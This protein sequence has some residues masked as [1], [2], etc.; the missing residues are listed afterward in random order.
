MG[1]LKLEY[2]TEQM[3]FFLKVKRLDKQG[4]KKGVQGFL[5]VDPLASKYASISPYSA[6][7]NNPILFIDTDGR[8]FF[9]YIKVKN[10]ESGKTELKKVTF[11][12]VEASITDVKTGNTTAYSSGTSQFVDNMIT[13]YNYVVSN[14]A[15]VDNAM[16]TVAGSKDVQVEIVESKKG[17]S[18][19]KGKIEYDFNFGLKLYNGET[20]EYLGNQSSAIGF[21]SE[22]YHSYVDLI[23]QKAKSDLNG[24]I[25]KEEDYVHIS[26]EHKV[27]DKLKEKNPESK[28]TKRT[29]YQA[30]DAWPVKTEGA[31]STDEKK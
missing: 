16:Q 12:G 18:Y 24:D 11:N 19:F 1:C 22:V 26:K 2:H 8:E 13:S 6:F 15:D 27:I 23:D 28:E 29:Q 5:S 21:W 31:T 14:G 17:G 9:T 30:G 10:E 4:V 20:N 7:A 3:P 25:D